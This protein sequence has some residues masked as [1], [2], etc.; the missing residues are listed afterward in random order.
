MPNKLQIGIYAD[1]SYVVDEIV[2]SK[3]SVEEIIAQAVIDNPTN[4]QVI[5]HADRD[6]RYQSVATLIDVCNR[7]KVASYRVLVAEESPTP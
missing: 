1:G 6:A 7:A 3:N 4:Q 2:V 5:I